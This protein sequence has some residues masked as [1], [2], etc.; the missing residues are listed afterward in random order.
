MTC[1]LLGKDSALWK[2]NIVSTV[3]NV[4]FDTSNA[5]ELVHSNSEALLVLT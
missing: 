5:S 1:Q 2:L 3:H 4:K